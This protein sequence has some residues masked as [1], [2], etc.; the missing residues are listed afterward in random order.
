MKISKKRVFTLFALALLITSSLL[1]NMNG[2]TSAQGPNDPIHLHGPSL[3]PI[4]MHSNITLKPIHMHSMQGILTPSQM[5]Q[6]NCTTDWHELYPNYCTEWHLSSWEDMGEP[7]GELSP[8][9]QIDMNNID[10]GEIEWFHVDRITITLLLSGPY[11]A[12]N[13]TEAESTMA[14]EL[15]LPFY[16]PYILDY[17][18]FLGTPWHEVW[19]NYS[20]FYVLNS[21]VDNPFFPDQRL[22][23]CDSIDLIDN[24]GN[25]TYW[26]VED[27]ATDLILRWKMM[28][29]ICSWW[30]QVY[31]EDDYCTWYH[32]SSWV[33]PIED[34]YPGRLGPGDQIDMTENESQNVNWYFVD[35]LTITINATHLNSETG[36][37][38]GWHLLELKTEFFEEMYYYLKHPLYSRWHEVY[39][40]YIN[41]Y[42]LTYWNFDDP[43]SDNCNGVLDPCDYVWMLNETSQEEELFHIEDMCYDLI[44]NEKISDP[45]CTDWH[46][47]HPECCVYDYHVD[48]W[49]DNG[50]SLLSPCDNVRLTLLPTGPTEN[51]HVENM[52]LTLNLT[53]IDPGTGP[54]LPGERIYIEYLLGLQ[55]MELMYYPKID[56]YYTDW[57][58][59]CPTDYYGIVVTILNWVDHCNGVLS[60][61]DIIELF[62]FDQNAF[63]C[64]VD[65]VAVDMIV[66]K[67]EEPIH[68]VA[69]IDVFSLIPWVY[70]GETDPIN[71]TVENQGNQIE[72]VDVFAFYD[73]N[74]AAPKQTIPLNPGQNVT[75]TFNWDT[76]GVSPGFYTVSANATIAIDDDPI[77]NTAIGNTQEV[78]EP[79]PFYWKEPYPEYAP[80]GV[81]DFDQKQDFWQSPWLPPGLNWSWC[82]PT[83]VANSLWWMDSRFH[84]SNLLTTYTGA[85]SEHDPSNV[86]PFID[87]LSYLMDTDG[88]RTSVAHI[89]TS[90]FDMEAGIA[91]YLSWT[92][93]N[94]QGDV[95][96]DGTVDMTDWNI[97]NNT[98]GTSPGVAGWDLQADIFPVTTGW[99]VPGIADN[100]I[101]I[102]DLNLVTANM[103]K[104]GTFYEHTIPSPHFYLIEEELERCQDIVLLIAP[105]YGQDRWDEEAHFVTVAGI[106]SALKKIAFSDPMWD[107]FEMGL[108]PEGRVLPPGVI[109]PHPPSPPDT[110]HNN[111]SLVSHDIYNVTDEFPCP[112]G[113]WSIEGYPG[114]NW[115]TQ[116]G[117][118]WQ[119]EY[120]VIVSPIEEEVC[121]VNI[122]DVTPSVTEA[123]STWGPCANM[124]I[125]VT[126]HNNGTIATDC[127]V[128]V[129]YLNGSTWVLIGTQGV[130]NL[131]PCNPTTLQFNW[132]LT[133]VALLYHT[134]KAN[135]TCACGAGDE[136]IDGQVLI[137]LPGDVNGDRVVD[138]T[139]YGIFG[140]AW[141]PGP[142]NLACDFNCDGV[143]DSTDYGMLGAN[144]GAAY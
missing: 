9:D 60:Y 39:P 130:T 36:E 55:D 29:P 43:K 119:I 72:L 144:W 77:D 25:M 10:T 132:D 142:Y 41:V 82:G 56:P 58:I 122:T 51:Y 114:Y 95:N 100:L 47:L 59:V 31:P 50:D 115:P 137:K 34:W 103:G 85:I 70:Q 20:N 118:I 42:N 133:G 23:P 62:D 112:G 127:T 57:V 99:P 117:Y 37:P 105:Y 16:D 40:S 22:S 93:A 140:V 87:H 35:R 107:A 53:V 11:D 80:S 129:Y 74:M 84:P 52:T 33:E 64:H 104:N 38:I 18:L 1:V 113:L 68:D 120:A 26:H 139:D 136:F 73:G 30:H 97:V 24:Y 2:P 45:V 98:M 76:T 110:T 75:L 86:P 141:P 125:N 7:Y 121:G 12:Y 138:S 14:I 89:G 54:Y 48:D 116:P 5:A 69:V 32:L 123:Y 78:R 88:R 101:N 124:Y 102:N 90:V 126:V 109:H 106:D 79:P 27:V 49:E 3:Q 111:A 6:P 17:P 92:G 44:L 65:E 135:F 28:D 4:H 46:E 63:L 67:I 15:K 71:V 8:N 94:P 83:A 134:I 66:K 91:Q 108:T 131:V 21:W 19:K 61:C 96:G 143:I 13:H 81:P 128:N